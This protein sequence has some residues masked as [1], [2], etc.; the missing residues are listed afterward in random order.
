MLAYQYL[1]TLPQIA[2]GQSNK[3]WVVPAELTRALEGFG[4]AFGR[5]LSGAGG[6]ADADEDEEYVPDEEV[7]Q[8]A[9]EAEAEAE[10]A[11]KAAADAASEASSEVSAPERGVEGTSGSSDTPRG[12][13]SAPLSTDPVL[14]TPS[15]APTP[16]QA[17]AR[18]Q[19][20]SGGGQ[21][22]TGHAP[23]SGGVYHG[24]QHR[25]NGP[26]QG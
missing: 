25:P 26:A 23:P 5:A 19:P 2:A 10:K 8:F 13:P 4:G 21:P 3:V 17:P 20:D 7:S 12:L 18:T 15:G 22:T 1:Q 6:H 16:E 11:A 24:G 9:P 14:G